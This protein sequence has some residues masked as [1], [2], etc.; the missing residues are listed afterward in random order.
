MDEEVVQN[1]LP[2]INMKSI[3]SFIDSN[4]KSPDLIEIK[5]T[6]KKRQRRQEI[7]QIDEKIKKKNDE[8]KSP[9]RGQSNINV[10]KGFSNNN[11]LVTP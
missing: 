10:F 7:D 8:E 5:E 6:I 9:K 11:L 3:A 2:K 4:F 1:S